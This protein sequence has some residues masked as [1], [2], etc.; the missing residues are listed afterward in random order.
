MYFINIQ[1]SPVLFRCCQLYIVLLYIVDLKILSDYVR[2]LAFRHLSRRVS[3][4]FHGIV[5]KNFRM[6]C[7]MPAGECK[8]GLRSPK[9]QKS[10]FLYDFGNI[11]QNIIGHQKLRDL[12]E[13]Q[14]GSVGGIEVHTFVQ[15]FAKRRSEII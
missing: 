4:K 15:L 5:P 1:L 8:Q 9:L 3:S 13:I 6:K 11:L 12:A 2:Q 14:N 7:R 10:I